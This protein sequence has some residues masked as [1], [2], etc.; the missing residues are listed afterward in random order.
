M[1]R[2]DGVGPRGHMLAVYIDERHGRIAKHVAL[3]RPDG[4]TEMSELKFSP[5][6]LA[7]SC[8]NVARA[9]KRTD[10]AVNPPVDESFSQ[11]RAIA[12]ARLN[13]L[14]G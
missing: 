13:P 1:F 12:L 4:L 5:A 10:V 6:D 2:T 7:T 8:R 9:I 3:L 11:Y 14:S